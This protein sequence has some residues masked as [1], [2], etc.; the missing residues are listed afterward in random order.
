MHAG[1]EWM[2]DGMGAEPPRMAPTG[3]A[4][5]AAAPARAGPASVE[6]S[7]VRRAYR[8]ARRGKVTVLVTRYWPRGRRKSEFYMWLGALSPS[9]GLLAR[10]R[11]GGMAWGEFARLYTE[12]LSSDSTARRC[13]RG[14]HDMA[15]AGVPLVLCCFEESGMPCHRHLLREM[16]ARGRVV[17]SVECGGFV[18]CGDEGGGG[19][20]GGGQGPGQNGHG[21]NG[22]RHGRR[23]RRGAQ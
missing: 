16:V 8:S 4:A 17:K 22:H 6:T 2:A 1:P 7:S 20:G 18:D 10:Y 21:Q 23:S 3:T 14:L 13:I 15:E 9:P 11:K 12:Q 19:G 5:A